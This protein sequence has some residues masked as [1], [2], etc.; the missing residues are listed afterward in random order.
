MSTA[1]LRAPRR[2][3]LALDELFLSVGCHASPAKGYCLMEAVSV[4]A[5]EPWSDRPECV[6][7]TIARFLRRWN[8]TLSWRPRQALK[9]YICPAIGTRTTEADEAERAALVCRW[10]LGEWAPVWL[11][12]AGLDDEA[13]A[14]AAVDVSAPDGLSADGRVAVVA[15]RSRAERRSAQQQ[16]HT[17]FLRRAARETGWDA[18]VAALIPE[19]WIGPSGADRG[20]VLD[21]ALASLTAAATGQAWPQVGELRRS[22]HDLV[23]RL[24]AVGQPERMRWSA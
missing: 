12:L 8:D 23:S 11:R 24:C 15:V 19:P 17:S 16:T 5:G 20:L 2:Q 1:V 13:T 22:A 6:S 3:I 10:L 4:V 21:A 14:L 9:R 18:A 7:P